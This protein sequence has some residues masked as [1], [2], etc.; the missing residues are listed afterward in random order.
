MRD[1]SDRSE[2]VDINELIKRTLSY[3]MADNKEGALLLSDEIES[4]V[5]VVTK[6]ARFR[7]YSEVFYR[8]SCAPK[9]EK[10]SKDS[11]SNQGPDFLDNKLFDSCEKYCVI[12]ST[13]GIEVDRYIKRIMLTDASKAVILDAMFSAYL[14]LMTD[15]YEAKNIRENHS[16]RYAPGYGQIDISYNKIFFDIM[17]IEKKL[18]ITVSSGGI[19]LPQKSMMGICMILPE[20]EN[21]LEGDKCEGC[22]KYNDCN[23][24]KEDKRCWM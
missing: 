2:L 12:F 14:E 11:G 17:G 19:F 9:N 22:I 1:L 7:A 20:G 8:A 15:K 24:R 3:L 5:D 16:F 6:T 18:G 23:Y 4:L 13:L 21:P 10:T